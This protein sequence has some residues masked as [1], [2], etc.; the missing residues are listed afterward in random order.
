[1]PRDQACRHA[2]KSSPDVDHLD[3]LSPGLAHDEHAAARL[4]PQEPL[5]LQEG[6]L[7]AYRSPADPELLGQ[8]PL[9]EADLVRTR[10]DLRRRSWVTRAACCN[11]KKRLAAA[12]Q[13]RHFPARCALEQSRKLLV[14]LCRRHS[15]GLRARIRM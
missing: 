12:L 4:G 10:I 8:R 15:V 7:L 5:L 13:R 14:V 11:W 1:M 9:I 6:H 2:F 3:D